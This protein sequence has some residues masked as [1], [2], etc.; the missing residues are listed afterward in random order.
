MR[1]ATYSPISTVAAREMR[2]ASR[3]ARRCPLGQA[4]GTE[5][6]PGQPATR[7]PQLAQGTSGNPLSDGIGRTPRC[8][9]SRPDRG[10]GPVLHDGVDD[11][12]AGSAGPGPARPGDRASSPPRASGPRDW[13]RPCPRCRARCRAPPRKSP[14]WCRCW[15]PARA[16]PADQAGDLVAQDVAEHVGGHHDVELLRPHHQLHGGVV[17]DHVVG[18]DPA[19]VFLGDG[20]AHLEE[21]AA[22]HLEDVRLVHDG[23]LLPAVLEGVL[24]GV[25]HDPLAPRRVTIAIDSPTARGS[26]P[27]CTKCSTPM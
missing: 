15:R 17:H 26:S 6:T 8:W 13:R 2:L 9:R 18:L 4:I 21:Q 20:A 5:L 24:E 14:P 19:L 16:Q 11:R 27:I 23:D 10:C 25:A 12:V 7:R 1:K 22:H 3:V